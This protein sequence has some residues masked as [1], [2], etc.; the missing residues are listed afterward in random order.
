MFSS[1]EQ[2]VSGGESTGE[3]WIWRDL[4][5]GHVAW[6]LGQAPFPN[7]F[8]HRILSVEGQWEAAHTR[9]GPWTFW[10]F[11]VSSI[12][13]AHT[14]RAGAWWGSWDFLK[15]ASGMWKELRVCCLPG[16]SLPFW[17]SGHIL[18]LPQPIPH[19]SQTSQRAAKE[20]SLH[21]RSL[22][23]QIPALLWAGF[24]STE[25]RSDGSVLFG[26]LPI[27]D[28]I[29]RNGG[30]LRSSQHGQ[31]CA[32]SQ[33][34]LW[35]TFTCSLTVE[36]NDGSDPPSSPR[37]SPAPLPYW[38]FGM[39]ESSPSKW[40]KKMVHSYVANKYFWGDCFNFSS[41]GMP[42]TPNH[43]EAR[44]VGTNFPLLASPRV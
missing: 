20:L 4:N 32:H 26:S 11:I 43:R 29:A 16:L 14:H 30:G 19:H 25:G 39:L 10:A 8:M 28:M 2:W 37:C 5:L 3:I 24:L 40:Y 38:R 33:R 23:S 13:W 22:L 21:G 44:S 41:F 12:N 35:E 7:N 9:L 17:V 1:Q 6:F 42:Q 34:L 27:S 15:P 36:E 18:R 31:P